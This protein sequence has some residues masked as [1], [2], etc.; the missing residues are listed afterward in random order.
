MKHVT[1]PETV[2]MI[3]ESLDAQQRPVRSVF[4]S[5]YIPRRCGIATFTKDLTKAINDLNPDFLAKIVALTDA[6]H[7]YTYPPEVHYEI[8]QN[9]EDDYI[10]VAEAINASPVEIVCLQHEYG[11][12]GGGETGPYILELLKR[13]DKPIV[14]TLHTI[15]ENPGP[16]HRKLL[17]DIANLSDILITQLPNAR[18]LLA[19]SYD[20]NSERIVV[21]H[22]GVADRPQARKILKPKF[23]WEH[24]HVMLLSG[25]ISEGKGIEYVI[26]ALPE[27]VKEFPDTLFVVAG[28]THPNVLAERGESY[29]E[30]LVALADSLGVAEHL[31]LINEYLPLEKL[32]EYYEACDVYLTPHLDPQQVSS[33]TLAYA[34]GMGKACI[35][36]PY[37]YAKEMLSQD[38]G[39]LVD[40]RNSEQIAQAALGLFSGRIPMEK[41]EAQAYA[42]GRTMSWP[43]VA[44][45]YL[46]LFRL[47]LDVQNTLINS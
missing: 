47:V 15:L 23:G 32:L 13:L 16:L 29:R 8:H 17:Q 5:S 43:R 41:M 34:I 40:F 9:R 39:I 3:S 1:R 46:N 11:L 24:K 38:R 44:E 30:S 6:E 28:Q 37:I 36:T 35:S 22:H 7:Q 2:R 26:Q 12:F 19:K 42:L 25:L 20:I 14:T 10:Q 31:Q 45:R 18:E 21:V 27:I 33:G 4:I